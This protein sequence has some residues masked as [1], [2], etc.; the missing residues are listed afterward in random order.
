M[1]LMCYHSVTE[2]VLFLWDNYPE[3]C[4]EPQP[5]D[6]LLISAPQDHSGHLLMALHDYHT[7]NNKRLYSRY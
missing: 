2:D 7:I 5:A 3:A 1:N 6:W 4:A